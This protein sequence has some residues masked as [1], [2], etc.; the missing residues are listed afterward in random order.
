MEPIARFVAWAPAHLRVPS[1]EADA[2]FR[3]LPSGVTAAEAAVPL[4]ADPDRLNRD[5]EQT[6]AAIAAAR[7]PVEAAAKLAH[8]LAREGDRARRWRDAGCPDPYAA[9]R[10]H[11]AAFLDDLRGIRKAAK[12][13]ARH[14]DDSRAP[15]VFALLDAVRALE[16]AGVS[17]AAATDAVA[18]VDVC[19]ALARF[20]RAYGEALETDHLAERGPMLHRF[21]AAPFIFGGPVQ[22]FPWGDM[23]T[24]G[25]LWR[26]TWLARRLTGGVGSPAMGAPLPEGGQPLWPVA[27]A[28]LR[29]VTG[30]HYDADTAQDVLA[31]FLE[32]YPDVGFLG[33]PVPARDPDT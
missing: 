17:I 13:L 16:E 10:D 7:L 6:R 27:A 18:P 5:Y 20:L 14:F 22:R 24:R 25:L 23:L 31:H 8:H 9:R 19:A 15:T 21:V 2:W 29:D 3:R 26:A 30:K 4:A 28:L 12:T 33:W 1:P 32:R 11:D